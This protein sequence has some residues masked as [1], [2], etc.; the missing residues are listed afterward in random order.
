MVVDAS[1]ELQPGRRFQAASLQGSRCAS[2]SPHCSRIA[3]A[4]EDH[5]EAKAL[6]V[7]D[8]R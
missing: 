5:L 6:G 7:L 3:D 2:S 1:H 4:A 8:D